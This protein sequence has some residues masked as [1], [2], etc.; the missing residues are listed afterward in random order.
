MSEASFYQAETKGAATYV[1]EF[2][3]ELDA[4]KCLGCGRCYK[5]CGRTVFTLI[6]REDLDLEDDDYEDE[7]AM[8][9]T[10]QDGDDCIGCSACHRVCPRSCHSFAPKAA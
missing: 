5:V 3:E 1:P 10:I 4:E 9:M 8:V 6:D 2:I 7:G